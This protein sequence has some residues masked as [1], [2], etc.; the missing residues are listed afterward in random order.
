MAC[1]SHE[2]W[3]RS[4]EAMNTSQPIDKNA[5]ALLAM[6][7]ERELARRSTSG[8]LVYPA[9]YL[10][11]LFSTPYYRDHARFLVT[12]GIL[13]FVLSTARFLGSLGLRRASDSVLRQ[14]SRPFRLLI[15]GQFAVWG[16]LCA[17]T[18]SFY[19]L[20]TGTSFLMMLVTIGLA[21]G[22]TNSLAAEYILGRRALFLI[23]FPTIA[24]GASFGTR[25]GNALAVLTTIFMVYLMVQIRE[26]W[27][28][29]R[30]ATKMM[31]VKASRQTEEQLQEITG[32][33]GEAL[34]QYDAV[35]ERVLY[36]NQA[37]EKIWG[38]PT[39][40]L[41]EA[42]QILHDWVLPE[43]RTHTSDVMQRLK[44]GEQILEEF[45]IL[46]PDGSFRWVRA[47]G[48]PIVSDR[49][50]TVR[51]AGI[52]LDITEEKVAEEKRQVMTAV[53]LAQWQT[54]VQPGNLEDSM[55][56]IAR[57]AA[58]TLDVDRVGIWLP[59]EDRKRVRCAALYQR[60]TAQFLSGDELVIADLPTYFQQLAAHRTIAADDA[61]ADPRTK[62][63]LDGYILPVGITSMMDS[64]IRLEGLPPGVICHEHLGGPRHWSAEDQMFAASIGDLIAMTI[65]R[66]RQA[67]AETRHRQ[68]QKLEALGVLA[69]G[70]AHDFNNILAAI[71]GFSELAMRELPPDSPSQSRLE[72]IHRAGSRAADLVRQ[73]L[74][75]SSHSERQRENVNVSDV[76]HEVMTLLRAS[77]PSTIA[78][79][80]DI[81]RDCNVMA[82]VIEVQQVLI[83][84]CTNSYQAMKE[85]G[86]G[87]I[88]ITV[89]MVN[90]ADGSI[91]S[92]LGLEDGD[93][94]AISVSDSGPGIDE[95]LRERIFDPFFTTKPIGHG[96]GL[97][98]AVVH[99][100]VRFHRGAIDL[101]STP[102]E[103][104]T[105]FVYLPLSGQIAPELAE[106][107]ALM[108]PG[109]EHILFV[110][111]EDSLVSLWQ[112]V[113]EQN[114]YTVTTATNGA[115]AF[116]RFVAN[117]GTFDLL[118]TDVTMPKMA[119]PELAQRVF[120]IR[121]DMPILM[122]TGYTDTLGAIN[123]RSLGI[124][125][126]LAKPC[127]A[128]TL[129]T[130]VRQ[131][132][133]N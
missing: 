121:P 7:A 97:G 82:S 23:I 33:L 59:S 118:I 73:I 95:E 81:R 111:D 17:S 89:D 69:G 62:E 113:F 71:N 115:E 98:L 46:R 42:R 107:E 104:A 105:F 119:G 84:L 131:A 44:N 125:G 35:S 79:S 51:V 100:I 15:Y 45:R 65:M 75:F 52:S 1:N 21:A 90:T 55:R 38:R 27:L 47:T 124:R 19:R 50:T 28:A 34:W 112:E 53:L 78:I 26:N 91:R 48:H 9:V 56:E 39:Q 64:S 101:R 57:V 86:D 16:T 63:L 123:L 12:F 58:E 49:N 129:L 22:A 6:T 133:D 85:K 25:I 3:M 130:A 10:A 24:V 108:H 128:R 114:G 122:T 70:I 4:D 76:V 54:A 18:I 94:V 37:F 109:H 13:T 30:E 127:P 77:I 120:E 31:A 40:D 11:I 87:A 83:N 61:R 41:T 72:Q 8:A 80:V 99:G 132:L 102:G 36:V 2:A 66:A 96:T 103:G 74:A 67:Q 20:A 110:D 93:Y 5:D 32:K 126:T 60:R 29:Q 117:P 92:G 106:P 14:W 43:D 116:E 68:A 88:T